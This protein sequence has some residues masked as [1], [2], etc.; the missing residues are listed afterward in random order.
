MPG[1]PAERS[2]LRVGDII[3]EY[4]GKPVAES[5]D[6][7][8]LVARTAIGTRANLKV[9]RDQKELPISVTIAELKEEEVIAAAPQKESA[10]GVTV[11]NLTP[12]IAQTLGIEKMQGV[13]ISAVVSG[14]PAEDAGLRRGDVILEIDRKSIGNVADYKNAMVG[15]KKGESTLFLVQRGQTTSFIAFKVPTDRAPS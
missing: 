2:D 8:L 11:Q 5:N 10:F 7:P 1:S 3:V 15:L 14:S 12:E 6:L 9:L 13:V 4:A